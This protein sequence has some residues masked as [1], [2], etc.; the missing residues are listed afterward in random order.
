MLLK[1]NFSVTFVLALVKIW[2]VTHQQ[3]TYS[4]VKTF[5]L[6]KKLSSYLTERFLSNWEMLR[7]KNLAKNTFIIASCKDLRR[8]MKDSWK[9]L[10]RFSTQMPIIIYPTT[11]HRHLLQFLKLE[12]IPVAFFPLHT[13]M[14]YKV[15]FCMLL[16]SRCCFSRLS[17]IM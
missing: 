14:Y 5:N 1:I 15:P 17:N 10:K 6:N 13:S 11:K 9:I 2:K 16:F 12:T 3:S 7:I 4:Q 8:V